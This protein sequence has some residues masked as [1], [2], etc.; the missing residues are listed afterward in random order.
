MPLQVLKADIVAERDAAVL[1]E[2]KSLTT[3]NDQPA[4]EFLKKLAAEK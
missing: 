3:I 1:R 4:A 2:I